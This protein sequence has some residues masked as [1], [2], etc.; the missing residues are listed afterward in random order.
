MAISIKN[1]INVNTTTVS[2]LVGERDF[3]GLVF[4][5]EEMSA[6]NP[7]ASLSEVKTAYGTIGNAVALSYS[8]IVALFGSDA[9]IT[10]FAAKYFGYS[11][12]NQTPSVLNVAKFAADGEKTAFDQ[13]IANFTNFGSVAFIDGD[14]TNV[15]QI[16]EAAGNIGVVVIGV[17]DVDGTIDAFSDAENAHTVIGTDVG[18]DEGDDTL[19]QAWMVMAWYASVNYNQPNTSAS[20]MYKN[21]A[22]EQATITEDAVKITADNAHVNYIGKVQVYGSNIQFYQNGINGDGKTELGIY[23][24]TIWAKSSI[25]TGWF[26]LASSA[27]KIPANASGAG[28]VYA[29]VASVAAKGVANGVILAD[30]NLSVRAQS[31]ILQYTNDAEAVDTVQTQG[32]YVSAKIVEDDGK[33]ACQ[34]LLVYAKGDSIQ[35]VEGLHVLV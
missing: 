35:K 21:F 34:Y 12:G 22:D 6:A 18:N 28:Y 19:Y 24:D 15:A 10:K 32:Y 5:T 13:V 25:E 7:P 27:R 23:R 17:I 29:L 9:K 4:T 31:E 30:K 8:E 1:Y 33:Y 20:I 26:N 14:N 3:S 11:S 2:A 16:V